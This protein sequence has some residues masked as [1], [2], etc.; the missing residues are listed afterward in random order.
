[1]PGTDEMPI[2]LASELWTMP[3]CIS[4]N[5]IPGNQKWAMVFY[6]CAACAGGYTYAVTEGGMLS[7]TPFN[8]G[9]GLFCMVQL[10]CGLKPFAQHMGIDVVVNNPVS[11]IV[12][13]SLQQL[14]PLLANL[15]GI[16]FIFEIKP[17]EDDVH[18]I[19]WKSSDVADAL[20]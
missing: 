16:N 5:E 20:C 17:G 4:N 3:K 9:A 18:K 12:C 14:I 15:A 1:M 7:D 10:P 6:G 13:V 11:S 19:I 8:Q 2:P